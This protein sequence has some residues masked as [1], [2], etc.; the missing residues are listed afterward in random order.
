[1]H[2]SRPR[3]SE[4]HS[5]AL[6]AAVFASF[7]LAAPPNARADDLADLSLEEL[8]SIEVYSVAKK[9]QKIAD[10]AA[11]V[12]VLTQEDIRR[13]GVTTIPEAL[14][15]VPGVEVAHIDSNKWA[16]TIRGFNERFSNKLLVLIDGRTVYTPFFAG[17]YWDVQDLVLEDVD[18]IEVI[19]GPGGTLWGAN[20]VNGV[21]NIITKR[22]ADTQGA[23]LSGGA[24]TEEEGFATARYGGKLGEN[25]YARVYAKYFQRDDF[26]ATLPRASGDD[27]DD[28]W[29]ATRGGFR[30]DWTPSEVD[31]LTL[32]G[33][34]YEGESGQFFS[35][36]APPPT[37]A[38]AGA[39]HTDLSGG[40]VLGRWTRKLGDESNFQLQAYYDLTQ[41]AASATT[42]ER[43]NVA[44]IEFQHR[45]QIARRNDLVWGLGYRATWDHI[46]GTYAISLQPEHRTDHLVSAFV[47][48]EIT[49]LD[50][51]LH[52]TLGTKLEY[53][54]YSGFEVQPSARALWKPAER[55]V[56]WGAISRAVRTPSR[57]EEDIRINRTTIPAGAPGTPCENSPLPC[58][59][60]F[61]GDSGFE[62]EDLTA[63][64]V[65]Y[66]TQL[67][68]NL[69]VDVTSYYNIYDSLRTTTP[70]TPV[71]EATPFQMLTI[72]IVVGNGLDATT[73]G[74]EVAADWHPL[75]RWKLRAGYTFLEMDLDFDSDAQDD[76]SSSFAD[77]SSP[78]NQVFA[79]SLID[80][81]YHL[82]LDANVKWVDELKSLDVGSYTQLDLRLGWRP[83][84]MLEFSL[85]GQ[86]LL[87]DSNS[88]FRSSIFV[89][90]EPTKVQRGVYGKITLRF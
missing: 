49:L 61:V 67:M 6:I 37:F 83:T 13:S 71:V 14:R 81:P 86:N 56:V 70:S 87:E 23:L 7:L 66:R 60:A 89:N 44:D 9:S 3:R 55:H 63:F 33:D 15:F 29:H 4:H 75:E 47:Q 2:G 5:R 42:N 41:R 46:D 18:R 85:V 36:S 32:Q 45:F 16:I 39:S 1:M 30:I 57:A 25:A 82:E 77:G 27:G 8:M 59:I 50:D 38:I 26:K 88:Q 40:N 79:R 76:V 72:P 54:D 52:V 12:Y 19:R 84:E 17:V 90:D 34:T 73:W 64:E 62:A 74:F 28:E 51:A 68:D 65:G 48:D 35:V 10:S 80:L 58:V 11:A 31:E 22:A 43:R 78:Q 53:N 21:I 24:G 69:S 20:A